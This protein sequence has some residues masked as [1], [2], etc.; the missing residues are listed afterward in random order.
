MLPTVFVTL[1]AS[2][3][4]SVAVSVCFVAAV[5]LDMVSRGIVATNSITSSY[6]FIS[7]F[8]YQY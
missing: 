1:V 7:F 3:L 5:V 2:P 4:A 6:F 8:L